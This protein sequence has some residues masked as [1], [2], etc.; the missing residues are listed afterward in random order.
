MV[1]ETGRLCVKTA[2]RDAGRKCI[3]VE[4]LDDEFVKIDGATRRRKC[5][6][7]HL[8][9]LKKEVEIEQG[10]SHKKVKKVFEKHNWEVR[11]TGSKPKKEKKKKSKKKSKSKSSK[12][13]NKSSSSK[14]S[15]S[16]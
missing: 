11:E 13:K 2:G 9:P 5:N 10:A 8:E 3:I 6:V 4:E 15:K 14:K 1:Y 16:E 7:K 12:K